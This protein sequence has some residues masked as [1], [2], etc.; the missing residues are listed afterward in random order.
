MHCGLRIADFG[1]RIEFLL[2]CTRTEVG[3]GPALRW[4]GHSCLSLSGNSTKAPI[5]ILNRS[6]GS[7][8]AQ[9]QVKDLAGTSWGTSLLQSAGDDPARSFV[10]EASSFTFRQLVSDSSRRMSREA[11]AA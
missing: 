5:V 1:L 11:A 6:G 9:A 4:G 2:P 3:W 8:A 7:Q 10:G